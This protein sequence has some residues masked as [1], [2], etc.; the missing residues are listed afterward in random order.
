M[1]ARTSACC[2]GLAEG[3]RGLRRFLVEVL[4]LTVAMS[5]TIALLSLVKIGGVPLLVIVP[6]PDGAFTLDVFVGPARLDLVVGFVF[7]VTS[8]CL[9]VLLAVLFGRWYLRH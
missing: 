6:D 8:A 1:R 7:A 4:L 5:A 9:P 2:R 3:S